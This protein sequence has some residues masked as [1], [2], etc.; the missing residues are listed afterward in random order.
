MAFRAH[1]RFVQLDYARPGFR[2][3]RPGLTSLGRSRQGCLVYLDS[4]QTVPITVEACCDR[5]VSESMEDDCRF[6]RGNAELYRR[7]ARDGVWSLVTR[8][9]Y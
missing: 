9:G 5:F 2:S 1:S 3:I 4:Y 6:D 8:R 7:L